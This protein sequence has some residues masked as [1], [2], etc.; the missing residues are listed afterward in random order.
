MNPGVFFSGNEY[1]SVF[2]ATPFDGTLTPY[3]ANCFKPEV[4]TCILD[5]EMLGYHSATKTFGEK[6]VNRTC[7]YYIF[8][9][10]LITELR[11]SHEIVTA[12]ALLQVMVLCLFIFLFKR[13][14]CEVFDVAAV[15]RI[16]WPTCLT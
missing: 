13:M 9:N 6:V 10:H 14:G 11:H 2:G 3:I 4:K 12:I 16:P 1:T 8:F 7:I 15:K 5:G